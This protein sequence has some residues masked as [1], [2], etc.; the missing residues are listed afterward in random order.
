MKR[1]YIFV[2]MSLLLGGTALNSSA[3]ARQPTEL[4]DSMQSVGNHSLAPDSVGGPE[5]KST[6]N[7]KDSSVK[8]VNSDPNFKPVSSDDTFRPAPPDADPATNGGNL[9]P[10]GNISLDD[11]GASLDDSDD[12]DN[13]GTN[14]KNGQNNG[15]GLVALPD[16]SKEN[17]GAELNEALR[18][19]LPPPESIHVARQRRA[20]LE[21]EDASPVG[22]ELKPLTRTINMTLRPGE[23]PPTVHLA[24]GAVTT[25]TFSDETGS[26]WYVGNVVTDES[27]YKVTK[28]AGND[29][30]KSNIVTIYPRTRYSTGRNVSIMLEHASVPVI[31]QLDT[32]M[33]SN[34]VDYRAD[35][36]VMQRGP[37]AKEDFV[38]E[39]LAPA[40]DSD[41]QGFVDGVTPKGAKSLKTSSPSVEAWKFKGMMYIRTSERL[42]APIWVRKS[43]SNLSGDTVYVL[44]PVPDITISSDGNLSSVMIKQ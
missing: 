19:L 11:N 25:L 4:T 8:D 36:T 22:P 39:G 6:N 27:S 5:V 9:K 24:L 16:R 12:S 35:I 43:H 17:E 37:N 28:G 29:D 13:T 44:R 2:F 26:P 14:G 18:N 1:K 38:E 20:A 42:M 33:N 31:L 30:V 3:L 10:K 23:V 34:T 7:N 21:R 40:Q 32:A 15:N 41:I